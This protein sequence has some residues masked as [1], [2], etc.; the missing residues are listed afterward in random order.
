MAKVKTKII[1]GALVFA[2]SPMTTYASALVKYDAR[3]LDEILDK[4]G[5]T[6][7]KNTV[8]ERKKEYIENPN[9]DIV[10]DYEVV[11]VVEDDK[12]VIEPDG[13]IDVI[14]EE[15]IVV[16]DTSPAPI[17]SKTPVYERVVDIS[18]HQNPDHIDYDKFA[19]DIDGAILR[20]SI[21]KADTLEIRKDYQ[22]EKHYQQ[23]SQRGVP[24][25]FYHYS[26]A[27]NKAEAER[28]AEYV[29]GIIRNKLV[30]LPVYID[31]EDDKRQAKATKG[32]I[33]EVAQ[34]FVTAMNRNGYV[35]GIYSYPWFAKE[36]LTK[37]VRNNNEFWI[38]DYE[39]KGFTG[40]KQ[41][42]FDS[43]QFTHQ[44]KVKGHRFG[45]DMS[46]LYRDYPYIIRGKSHKPLDQ[47]V[48]EIINGKWGVG[49]DRVRRLEY[50]GYNYD[51]VQRAVNERM[52]IARG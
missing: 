24:L 8:E 2:L 51:I 35:A 46:V 42:D 36:Y 22:I 26:R 30:S 27:I 49:S 16:E 29:T 3:N 12:L 10:H 20:T 14:K 37:D 52:R 7:D 9:D 23:L 4:H 28:E 34:A 21:T 47:L 25:G 18:E 41:T 33:S 19:A 6:Y 38:A 45:V 13:S 11:E 17:Y 40:Y 15:T 39:S 1:I 48:T 5:I 50:A 44:A 32:Q 43:W 31:I